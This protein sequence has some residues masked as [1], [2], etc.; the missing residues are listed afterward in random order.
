MGKNITTKDMTYDE[1]LAICESGECP[2]CGGKKIT[3]TKAKHGGKHF[4]CHESECGAENYF[5]RKEQV[6]EA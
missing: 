6:N 3:V 2:Y 1:R 4:I 5:S